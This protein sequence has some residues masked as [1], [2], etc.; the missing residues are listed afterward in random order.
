ME[1]TDK[2]TVFNIGLMELNTKAI[3]LKTK[4]LVKANSLMLMATFIKDSGKMIR[5]MD[6]ECIFILK[7][8]P[9]IK[10]T[11][12]MICNMVQGYKYTLMEI[13][14]KGCLNKEK[15]TDRVHTTLLKDKYI[16]G[17]GLMEK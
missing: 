7:Q 6:M 11:G 15:E 5:L 10:D 16:R 14:M 13:S 2:D 1:I 9:N 3:G 4:L 12:R 17:N 8:E